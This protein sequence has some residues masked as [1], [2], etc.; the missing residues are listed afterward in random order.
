MKK[1]TTNLSILTLGVFLCLGTSNGQAQSID[2]QALIYGFQEA[3]TLAMQAV[4]EC[5]AEL[6]TEDMALLKPCAKQKAPG[7]YYMLTGL[8][9]WSNDMNKK[10]KE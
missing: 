9:R 4:E 8:E 7:P 6:K 2:M 3:S 5:K 1:K 10:K